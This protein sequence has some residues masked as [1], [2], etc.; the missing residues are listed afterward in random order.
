MASVATAQDADVVAYPSGGASVLDGVVPSLGAGGVTAPPMASPVAG[1]DATRLHVRFAPDAGPVL[2]G[3]E[4]S[5]DDSRVL[6][7][8]VTAGAAVEPLFD[9]PARAIAASRRQ[10][11]A[12]S[13]QA[14]PD[15]SR[16]Y[17]VTT[18]SI[19]LGA[20]LADTL[21]ASDAVDLVQAE[22]TLA[23]TQVPDEEELQGY[24]DPGPTGVEAEWAWGRPG[25]TGQNVRI[26]AIDSGFDTVHG[27]L[28]RASAPGVVI[29]HAAAWDTHHGLQVLG[30]LAADDDGAGVRGIA[31]GAALNT[32]TSGRTAS[33][34]ANALDLATAATSAG[35]VITIS[36]GICAVSGCGGGGVVLPLV[37]SAS[38]RDALRVATAKGVVA[39]VSA[40]NGGANLDGYADRLGDD[41]PEVIVVGAGNGA[42]TGCGTADG[43]ARG[44]VASSNYGSRVDLQGWGSCARTTA[45]G[46]GYRW[47]G[48]TSAATPQVAGAAALLS[49]MVQAQGDLL[50]GGQ[51]RGLLQATGSAQVVSGTRGGRIGPLPNVRA[52]LGAV[53]GIPAND[54]FAAARPIETLPAIVRADARLAGTEDDEPSVTCG[55][56]SSTLW[57]RLTPSVDTAVEI[58]T[59]GSDFDTL[60]GLWRDRGDGLERVDCA[61][62]RTA[63]DRDAALTT[64]LDGGETYFVQVGGSGGA[65]GRLRLSVHPAGYRGVGCDID[66][67]GRGDIVTGSPEEGLDGAPRAGRVV[68][69]HGAG[70]GTG[71]VSSVTQEWSGVAGVSERGDAFGAAVACGDFDGDGYDDVAIG[72]PKED[73]KK[74]SNAGSVRVVYGGGGGLTGRSTNLSQA[75]T[76]IAN[77]PESGDLFGSAL[78]AGDFDGDGIDDL[79]IGAKGEDLGAKV[80]AGVVHVVFGADAGLSGAGSLLLKGS[81]RGLP[82]SAERDDKFGATLAAGDF[83]GNGFD[84]LV[85]GIPSEDLGALTNAGAAIVVPGS[86]GGPAASG[87][88]ILHRNLSAV[89]GSAAAAERFAQA[90]AVGDIDGDGFDDLAVGAPGVAISGATGAGAVHVFAGSVFGLEAATSELVHQDTAGVKGVAEVGDG[91]GSA[92]SLGDLTG[93]RRDEL[94]VGAAGEAVGAA[95]GAG[96]VHVFDATAD[97]LSFAADQVLTQNSKGVPN[98]AEVGDGLGSALV[99]VD[100]N[101]DGRRDLVAAAPGEGLGGVRE[102]GVLVVARGGDHGVRKS[103]AFN[104]SQRSLDSG[105]NETGD[106]FGHSLHG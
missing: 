24:L 68:V 105:Q 88:I 37:Y 3:G 54:F 10:A 50:S 20:A 34:M 94:L 55:A 53:D 52:A 81:T 23:T 30:I 25:G 51:I 12:A 28:D 43:P 56:I 13:G 92:V 6:D 80:D 100:I 75:T 2:V 1:G 99:T 72:S 83:D 31:H 106:R 48:F 103:T 11:E 59:A 77:K 4:I 91:F 78:A 44:R 93:D 76:G 39:V 84:D 87:S 82:N 97:G 40:G 101:G 15:L 27:D 86:A 62:D 98:R 104:L 49:S 22:P 41:A 71:R 18:S 38:A 42:A 16:W 17:L 29:P 69:V 66:D 89:D 8:L 7:A 61:D 67:D 19:A 57:Y 58:S 73:S 79:A 32:V 85:V 5:L 14:Q 47:W 60:V 9:R 36:Q 102:S 96:L 63:N 45:Q 64:T 33:D 46:G 65:D 35:D 74:R 95:R 26:V 21:Q 70:S 90:L